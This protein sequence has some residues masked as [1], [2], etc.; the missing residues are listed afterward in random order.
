MRAK[1]AATCAVLLVTT[2]VLAGCGSTPLERGASGGG[3]GAA[4]GVGIAAIAGAPLL[5]GAA[6]GAAGGAAIGAATNPC[7]LDVGP[8]RPANC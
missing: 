8:N 7:Q 6:I 2:T 3:I 4:A 5:A 1:T